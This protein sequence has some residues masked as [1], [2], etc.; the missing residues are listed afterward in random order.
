MKVIERHSLILRWTHWFN[1][2][3]LSLMIWSGIL[4]YWANDEYFRIPDWA[5]QTF[6]LDYKLAEGLSW[7]F[8]IMWLFLINGLIYT[9]YLLISGEWREFIPFSQASGK[10]NAVQKL[11]YLGVLIMAALS[12]LSGLAIY[13]P[14]TMGWLT[15]LMGGY[16]ASRL[17][18]FI[19]MLGFIFFILVHVIQVL[20][21]GW[22]TFRSMI[23]GY[24]IEK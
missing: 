4:I 1:V 17:I 18:H 15:E 22:N 16:K 11:A 5:A 6:H 3:F 9:S 24:E 20:R 19:L 10:F 7:H 14:V 12:L 23:A 2:V 8:F 13:K 21:A